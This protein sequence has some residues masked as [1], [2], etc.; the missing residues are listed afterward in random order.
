MITSGVTVKFITLLYYY[1]LA[2]NIREYQT[3]N[4]MH[5][6]RPKIAV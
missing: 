4:I 1:F 2:N 6:R 5:L 3:M